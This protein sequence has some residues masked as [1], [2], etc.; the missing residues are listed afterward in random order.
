[1]IMIRCREGQL[2]GM[3]LMRSE[4]V[5]GGFG[6]LRLQKRGPGSWGVCLRL[7]RAA[8]HFGGLAGVERARSA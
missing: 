7:E 8:S 4:V 6:D 3:G 2:I 1:M 5:L